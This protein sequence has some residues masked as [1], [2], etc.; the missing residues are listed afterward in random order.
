MNSDAK[1]RGT[2]LSPFTES[3]IAPVC[4]PNGRAR[5]AAAKLTDQLSEASPTG[6]AAT[7]FMVVVGTEV[8]R[9][10]FG[11]GYCCGVWVVLVLVLAATVRSTYLSSSGRMEPPLS[12]CSGLW[13]PWL[14]KGCFVVL[15]ARASAPRYAGHWFQFHLYLHNRTSP[16]RQVVRHLVPI[17][18][19]TPSS[20]T[21]DPKGE[22]P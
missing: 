20:L 19:V 9:M 3:V 21:L 7:A 15:T 22:K 5:T 2:L 14:L 12:L 4:R 1:Q 13:P 8:M 6:G 18:P 11:L 16:L 10:V 17:P